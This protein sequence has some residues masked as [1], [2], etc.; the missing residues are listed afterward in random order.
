MRLIES[1][2]GGSSQAELA[3]LE[4]AAENGWLT[5]TPGIGDRALAVWQRACERSGKA[6]AVIRLEP[7]RASLWFL[8]TTERE[9]TQ[10][11]QVRILAALANTTGYVLTSNNARAFARL[12]AEADVMQQLLAADAGVH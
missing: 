2:G 1:L 5:L 7:K 12:G 10:T 4:S 6:F 9:W 11:E 3:A 8:L